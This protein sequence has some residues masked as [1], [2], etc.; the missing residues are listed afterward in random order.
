MSGVLEKVQKFM[1]EYRLSDAGSRVLAALSG[2]ADSVCLLSV[3]KKLSA[4]G[5]WQLRAFHLNHGLRGEEADR[6]ERFCVELCEKMQVP[7]TVAHKDAAAFAGEHGL[8]VEEAG[9]I[10]RYEALEAAAR[11][12]EKEPY[13]NGAKSSQLC[14][15]IAIAHHLDDQAETILHHLLRGSGL[16]GLSG[17]RPKNGRR[18]RPLLCLSRKEIIG[19]LHSQGQEWC[20]DS[21]N[22][23]LSYTRNRIRARLLPLMVSEVNRNASEHICRAGELISQA[24]EYLTEQA[25]AMLAAFGRRDSLPWTKAAQAS[26]APAAEVSIPLE[27]FLS[28]KP[29]IKSYLLRQ[30]LAVIAPAQKNITTVH[31]CQIEALAKKREGAVSSLPGSLLAGRGRDE[32]WIRRQTAQPLPFASTPETALPPPSAFDAAQA[33]KAASKK[34]GSVENTAFTPGTWIPGSGAG[35]AGGLRF[36]EI[37]PLSEQMLSFSQQ[38]GEKICQKKYTKWFDCDKIKGMLSV[39]TRQNGDYITLTGGGHK[40]VSRYMIDEKVP[41]ERR[42]LIPL[43]AEGNHILWIIGYRIS[44]YYKITAKTRHVLQ[45]E[46]TQEE[47]SKENGR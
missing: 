8:S 11:S 4:E 3:L 39:R 38:A 9:R 10:L 33:G 45:V 28:Q 42:G 46:K 34:R 25:D 29:I 14:V 1:D 17:M 36:T 31:F 41:R 30:M 7:L 43:L 20:E 15:R 21:T 32:L 24:D 22:A 35:M 37:F 44:D 13:G 23:D 12:W 5:G 16:R 27:Y 47:G 40:T 26:D 2:G 19:Y 18:I 6:D